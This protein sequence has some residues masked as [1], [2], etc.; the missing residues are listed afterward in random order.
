M[1][2]CI[3][4]LSY[5][6]SLSE[7]VGKE[8]LQ[9]ANVEYISLSHHTCEFLSRAHHAHASLACPCGEGGESEMRVDRVSRCGAPLLQMEIRSPAVVCVCRV[10]RALTKDTVHCKGY[11]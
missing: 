9:N 3:K 1:H 4:R 7:N 8:R 2:G 5:S 10:A 6:H 11:R